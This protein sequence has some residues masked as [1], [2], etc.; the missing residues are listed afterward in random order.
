MGTQLHGHWHRR[1][2]TVVVLHQL[3]LLARVQVQCASPGGECA[4]GT[5]EEQRHLQVRRGGHAGRRAQSHDG[6]ARSGQHEFHS[7]AVD[8][9]LGTDR[10]LLPGNNRLY[11]VDLCAGLVEGQEATGA[12]GDEAHGATP[13]GL[14]LVPSLLESTGRTEQGVA[15]GRQYWTEHTSW[16]TTPASPSP[17]AHASVSTTAAG[18]TTSVHLQQRI[19]GPA[20]DDEYG[21]WNG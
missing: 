6:R 10:G 12:G 2:R 9:S 4:G 7:V 15:D 5:A 8:A 11:C 18:S 3:L 16:T 17:P 20:D 21:E 13:A 1:P 19:G 14:Y